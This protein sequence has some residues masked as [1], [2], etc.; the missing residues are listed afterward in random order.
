MNVFDGFSKRFVNKILLCL[1]IMIDT[2][3]Q[4]A[5]L[6][7]VFMPFSKMCSLFLVLREDN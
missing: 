2:F 4:S 1:A 6:L 7:T 3:L 5:T